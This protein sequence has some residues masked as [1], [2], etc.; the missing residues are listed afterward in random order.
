VLG[1]YQS[2]WSCHRV[3]EV[4]AHTQVWGMRHSH[5]CTQ[6]C[7]PFGS[8]TR[9][10]KGPCASLAGH[11]LPQEK[12]ACK[13]GYYR[14]ECHGLHVPCACN[15]LD[16]AC[17][18]AAHHFEGVAL[19]QCHGHVQH[20]ARDCAHADVAP[21]AAAESQKPTASLCH[22]ALAARQEVS[23]AAQKAGATCG[24]AGGG[25]VRS[26]MSRS[27]VRVPRR[28]HAPENRPATARRIGAAKCR[29]TSSW[30]EACR[31]LS[32]LSSAFVQ[33]ASQPSLGGGTKSHLPQAKQWRHLWRPKA[34]FPVRSRHLEPLRA[35]RRQW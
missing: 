24:T 34:A 9:C 27:E 18:I 4:G 31:S 21:A 15:E 22:E 2:G 30:K 10:S 12:A 7:G 17:P 1:E 3:R 20:R 33:L 13:A 29:D 26:R 14:G 35:P 11:G 19:R 23:T 32:T 16:P 25:P 6:A 28:V 8:G 5:A